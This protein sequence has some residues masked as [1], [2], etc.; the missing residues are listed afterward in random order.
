MT[1]GKDPAAAGLDI[2]RKMFG[3]SLVD[4]R[5]AAVTDFTRPLEDLVVRYCFGEVWSRQQLDRKTRSM[6]TLAV[7]T[8]LGKPNQLRVHVQGAINNG[9]TPEEIRE[10]L[11]HAMVYSGVPAGVEAFRVASEVLGA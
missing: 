8:A 1:D 7:L 2:M 6:L 3:A 9:V 11:L 5:Q 10:V 4:E